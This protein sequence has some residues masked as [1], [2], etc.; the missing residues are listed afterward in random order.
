MFDVIKEMT[1]LR[2]TVRHS[3]ERVEGMDLKP[4]DA[5]EIAKRKKILKEIEAD[6]RRLEGY[7]YANRT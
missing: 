6:L 2:D 1:W 4:A 7:Q 5:K 3:I